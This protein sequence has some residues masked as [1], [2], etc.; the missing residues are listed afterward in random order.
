MTNEQRIIDMDIHSYACFLETEESNLRRCMPC[1]EPHFQ[2]RIEMARAV[3]D[4][5]KAYR[6]AI[7]AE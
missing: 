3:L 7:D 4:A 2:Q 6:D 1:R 5:L